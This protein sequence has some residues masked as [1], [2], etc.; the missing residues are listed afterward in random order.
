MGLRVDGGAQEA[1]AGVATAT[2]GAGKTVDEGRAAVA[3]CVRQ[4]EGGAPKGEAVVEP[5]SIASCQE[6]LACLPLPLHLFWY[7]SLCAR[8]AE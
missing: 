1:A 6:A 7:W 3:G 5:P 4:G 8:D 2:G